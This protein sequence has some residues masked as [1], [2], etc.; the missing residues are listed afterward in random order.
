MN[1]PASACWQGTEILIV[2]IKNVIQ[3]Q[4]NY[5]GLGLHTNEKLK[6]VIS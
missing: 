1:E 4:N 3:K 2:G 5:N 6:S